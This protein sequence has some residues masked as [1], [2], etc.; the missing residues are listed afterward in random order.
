MVRTRTAASLDDI[1]YSIGPSLDKDW[2]LNT[3]EPTNSIKGKPKFS[4]GVVVVVSLLGIMYHVLGDPGHLGQDRV[5][6]PC[7]LAKDCEVKGY[8]ELD[9]RDNVESAEIEYMDE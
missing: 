2:V 1:C 5:H 9:D 4:F 7:S 6:M 3:G 8:F